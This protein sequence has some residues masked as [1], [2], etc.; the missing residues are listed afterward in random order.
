AIAYP[1]GEPDAGLRT[2]GRAIDD[3][4]RGVWTSATVSAI[5]MALP[6]MV[7]PARGTVA[8]AAN[9]PEWGDVDI[10]ALLAKPRGVPFAAENDA[11]AAAVGEQWL[12]AAK[13][14][15]D[16]V[17][18]ALGT[19]IGSGVVI[20]GKLHHGAHLLAGEVAFFPMEQDHIRNPGW[21]HCL[22]GVA[23][24]RAA[25]DKAQELFGERAK[26][27][28]LFEAASSGHAEASGW[29]RQTQ[30]VLAM[31]LADIASLLDPEA[32][33]VGGGV[34]A[35]Q[36]EPFLAPIRDL[37]HGSTPVK[38]SIVLSTLGEDAQ[39]VGAVRLALDRV[40]AGEQVQ[41]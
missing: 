19:G 17:F 8:S 11:N 21:Q 38:T 34:A 5:G 25:A 28:E 12:G 9:L 30:E 4:V 40:D 7:D 22:E 13:G 41:A 39:I 29:L 36:G 31:A 20:D 2:G 14:M 16:F 24:G 32:I 3:L 18:V 6:G 37:V 26:A 35:A 33:I 23:G 15:R 10:G 27:G 1:G